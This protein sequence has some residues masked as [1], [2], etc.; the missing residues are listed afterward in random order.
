[1]YEGNLIAGLQ[2]TVNKVV[3]I[4]E[5]VSAGMPQ[6]WSAVVH[7]NGYDWGNADSRCYAR[8]YSDG[9]RAVVVLTELNKN[10]GTSVTNCYERIATVMRAAVTAFIPFSNF[11]SRVTWME[12]YERAPEEIDL[13]ALLWDTANVG[14]VSRAKQRFS[15]PTWH[16]LSESTARMYDVPWEELCRAPEL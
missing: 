2:E 4:R 11:P 9:V 7:H 3:P 13:V 8:I 12:Q 10:P 14:S 6:V 15:N 1:M 5:R 16:R